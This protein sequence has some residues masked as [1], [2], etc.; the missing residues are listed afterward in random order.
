MVCTS[1]SYQEQ[2]ASYSWGHFTILYL[3]SEFS[4]PE[5]ERIC[6][7]KERLLSYA[8][9]ALNLSYDGHILAH[10]YLWGEEFAYANTQEETFESREYVLS[11]GGH[12]IVHIVC[13]ERMGYSQNGFLKEGIA[14][15]IELDLNYFNAIESFVDFS[16]YH[17]YIIKT[18]TG[19]ASTKPTITRQIANDQ[20]DYEYYSYKQAGAFV[21]YCIIRFGIEAVK[22]F[23]ISTVKTSSVSRQ[24]DFKRIFGFTVAEVE[25]KFLNT[26]FP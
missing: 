16:G 13:F 6:I 22:A 14:T 21:S 4:Q 25:K 19:Y 5:V 24:D 23:Y 9:D 17:G 10:L 15:A 8:N 1:T 7:K 2:Y 11:D 12:E 3:E 18:D 20:F 26:Y